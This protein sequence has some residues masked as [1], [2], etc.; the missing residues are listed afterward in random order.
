MAA[1]ELQ[2]KYIDFSEK[3]SVIMHHLYFELT[4]MQ[5]EQ[6][7]GTWDYDKLKKEHPALS[8]QLDKLLDCIDHT[9]MTAIHISQDYASYIG[10]EGDWDST[11]S[12]RQLKAKEVAA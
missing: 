3:L 4:E 5:Q 7:D 9:E 2:Q 10:K 11:E 12:W 1:N 8:A 6:A